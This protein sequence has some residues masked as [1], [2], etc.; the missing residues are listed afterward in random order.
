MVVY[1][2]HGEVLNGKFGA[3]LATADWRGHFTV[4]DK[5]MA[6]LVSCRSEQE[7]PM[8]FVFVYMT[9]QK[10]LHALLCLCLS[11]LHVFPTFSFSKSH[12]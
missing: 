5:A 12:R 9:T 10:R 7:T 1:G 2:G 6:S 11:F 3:M 8:L 4:L